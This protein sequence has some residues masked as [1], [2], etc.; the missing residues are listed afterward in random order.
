[1]TRSA[2]KLA[3]DRPDRA[4]ARRA[5]LQW[6]VV[7]RADLR[8]A[9]L[10]EHGIARR[11]RD[12]W[13]YRLHRAAYAV[14]HPNP[15]LEGRFLAAVLACGARAVLSHFAAAALWGFV[16]WDGRLIEVS[17]EGGRAPSH[18]GIRT[19]RTDTTGSRAGHTDPSRH[20]RDIPGADAA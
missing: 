4:I 5:A 16:E 13:L 6:G 2:S 1:M 19:H 11:V 15:P 7:S 8:A 9:G 3:R 10:S 14:G 20:P 18:P 12:G 17:V